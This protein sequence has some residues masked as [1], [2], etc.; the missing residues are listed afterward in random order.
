[1]K[2]SVLLSY[3]NFWTI[4]DIFS[5]QIWPLLLLC[6]APCLWI[7]FSMHA[8]P[9][10]NVISNSPQPQKMGLENDRVHKVI[11][12]AYSSIYLNVRDDKNENEMHD[13]IWRWEWTR[14]YGSSLAFNSLV[15]QVLRQMRIGFVIDHLLQYL[16]YFQRCVSLVNYTA[17]CV[18]IS[19]N[20]QLMFRSSCL[21]VEFFFSFL[22]QILWNAPYMQKRLVVC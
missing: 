22:R 8:F 15:N 20:L 17:Y 4:G 13:D 16:K 7:K 12:S 21:T 18:L 2:I 11:L 3:C 9:Q 6:V 19:S 5:P 14:E 10:C 1:M